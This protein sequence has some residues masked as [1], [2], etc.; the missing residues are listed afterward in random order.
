MEVYI[1]GQQ[2]WME[3][4][5]GAAVSVIS[6]KILW[7]PVQQSS[8]QLRSATGQILELAGEAKVKAQVK[9]KREVVKIYIVKGECPALFG[10]DWI[11]TFFGKDWL[12]RL[13]NINAVSS[14]GVPTELQTFA[15]EVC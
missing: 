10:R 12:Q 1:N 11:N 3:I 7:I 13:I 6:Q 8:K 15:R 5:T 9:G 14:Q 4:D 2:V